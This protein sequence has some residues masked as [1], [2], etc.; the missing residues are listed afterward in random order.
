MY[1]AIAMCT[2]QSLYI[3]GGAFYI[4]NPFKGGCVRLGGKKKGKERFG[5]MVAVKPKREC[6]LC[7]QYCMWQ[8][9]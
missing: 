7:H 8:L 3:L 2:K 4:G 6:G 1:M 5:A 9:Q